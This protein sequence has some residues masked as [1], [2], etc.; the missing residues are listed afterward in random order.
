MYALPYW[1]LHWLRQ[2]AINAGGAQPP[3]SL[4][5]WSVAAGVANGLMNQPRLR[6]RPGV[7]LDMVARAADAR[8]DGA[9]GRGQSV[10]P[11]RA[12]AGRGPAPRV[13]RR[14]DQ[15]PR[16]DPVAYALCAAA[17]ASRDGAA[18]SWVE[19]QREQRKPLGDAR[20]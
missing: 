15:P 3:P 9:A 5:A 8:A 11:L 17:W 6:V 14:A 2:A 16:R 4:L 1:M 13:L 7:S 20:S 18:I 19:A 12:R 10:D